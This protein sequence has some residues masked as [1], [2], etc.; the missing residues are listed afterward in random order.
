MISTRWAWT[1]GW[2]LSKVLFMSNPR[3]SLLSLPFLRGATRAHEEESCS[4]ACSL[5]VSM[6]GLWF[7]LWN[8]GSKVD[9]SPQAPCYH[10]VLINGYQWWDSIL[11]RILF[12][13]SP[14]LSFHFRLQPFIINLNSYWWICT[15]TKY[16]I[17]SWTFSFLL[18][19]IAGT[20]CGWIN[21]WLL[22]QLWC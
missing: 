13:S 6:I 12:N 1:T 22:F 5:D 16:N 21:A 7:V 18:S 11:L 4:G 14:F 9:H 8:H 10:S 20:S 17:P 19:T 2:A 3:S 15:L